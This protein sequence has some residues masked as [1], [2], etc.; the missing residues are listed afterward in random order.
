MITPL[1]PQRLT[2]EEAKKEAEHIAHAMKRRTHAALAAVFGVRADGTGDLVGTGTY[3]AV[4][5]KP[6][7]LTAS[8]VLAEITKY[9]MLAHNAGHG[10]R[11]AA[12]KTPFC[13]LPDKMYDLGLAQ[14]DPAK[15]PEDIIPGDETWLAPS[16]DDDALERDIVFIHG[17][18]G[19]RSRFFAMANGVN[20]ESLPY[21]T[22]GGGN[23]SYPWF[24]P[25]IHIAI[26]Y[27]TEGVDES[28]RSVRLPD[29]HGLSGSAI[30]K[31]NR[32]ENPNWFTEMAKIVG[33]AFAWDQPAKSLIAIRVEE[34]SKFLRPA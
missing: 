9:P 11:P 4:D 19:E 30:W 25:S 3:L 12:L 22:A 33:V 8:H 10:N 26:D 23:S 24:D 21:W 17:W 34:V 15:L 29:P 27:P 1:P 5:G 32:S 7:L 18:P 14:I 6:Y 20:S 13:V 28:G 31:S 2:T 16:S